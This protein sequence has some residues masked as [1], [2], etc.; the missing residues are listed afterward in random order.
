MNNE[1]QNKNTSFKFLAIVI[2]FYIFVAFFNIELFYESISRFGGIV[3]KILPLLLFVFVMMFLVNK[4]LT[5]DLV[6][7]HLGNESG[8]KAYFY[9][10]IAGILISGPPYVLFPLLKDLKD[11]GMSDN[12]IAVF[13][14]NRNVKIPF[15]PAM[16]YYFGAGFTI[17]LSFYVIIFSILNGLIIERINANN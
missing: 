9:A 17:V 10:I 15:I 4:F 7:K 12:L 16:I 8:V 6:K 13:L 3:N 2:L 1:K 5:A 14:Y 11:K